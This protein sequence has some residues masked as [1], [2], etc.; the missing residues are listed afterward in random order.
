MKAK[1]L[2]WAT[3]GEIQVLDYHFLF[4]AHA[5]ALAPP[6][7]IPPEQHGEWRNAHSRSIG[8][9]LREWALN[10]PDTFES[11]ATLVEAEVARHRRR[12]F[13]PQSASM[14]RPFGWL[15]RQGFIQKRGYRQL[16]LA[17]TVLCGPRGLRDDRRGRILSG[18]PGTAISSG[19]PR[20]RSDSSSS[21][22]RSSARNRSRLL[23]APPPSAGP[24]S[25]SWRSRQ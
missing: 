15:T 14:K 22:I 19:V 10:C 7:T 8:K 1:Q 5:F 3:P 21:A 23:P 18:V 11:A 2:L 9:Q 24:P 6:R 16:K 13:S 20:A 17:C 4:G 12:A 25:S